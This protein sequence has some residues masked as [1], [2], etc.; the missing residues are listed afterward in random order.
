MNRYGIPK[1]AE[2]KYS[3]LIAGILVNSKKSIRITLFSQFMEITENNDGDL[4]FYLKAMNFLI[5]G[6]Y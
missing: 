6:M 1:V 4:E 3:R 2:K 5:K